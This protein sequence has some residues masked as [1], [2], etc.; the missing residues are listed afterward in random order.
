MRRVKYLTLIDRN[1]HGTDRQ[2]WE[3]GQRLRILVKNWHDP[4]TY[5]LQHVKARDQQSYIRWYIP[6]RLDGFSLDTEERG[7]VV[8]PKDEKMSLQ[9]VNRLLDRLNTDFGP[10]FIIVMTASAEA[11][12]R[13]DGNQQS[14]EIDYRALETQRG[15]SLVGIMSESSPPTS[16]VV[17]KHMRSL[18]P[19]LSRTCVSKAD[20]M[21]ELIRPPISFASSIR[22]FVSCNI[23][24][25]ELRKS[26][27]PSQ[28]PRAPAMEQ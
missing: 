26:S 18:Y 28:R 1:Q 14:T 10:N 25:A 21:S 17:V 13:N 6:R 23:V 9:A 12:L 4:I 3:R 11:L 8:N 20:P 19:V 5:L 27:W 16:V 15:P 7:E 2:H 22:I 24:S